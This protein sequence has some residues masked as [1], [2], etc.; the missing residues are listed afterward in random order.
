MN[1][2]APAWIEKTDDGIAR[3]GATAF[4]Q[5]DHHAFGAFNDEWCIHGFFIVIEFYR[6]VNIV[7]A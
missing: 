4:C 2:D 5:R 3:N 7:L 1:D 6:G